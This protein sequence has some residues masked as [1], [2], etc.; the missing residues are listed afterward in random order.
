[1][2]TAPNPVDVLVMTAADAGMFL[3][4]RRPFA[5]VTIGEEAG[6]DHAALGLSSKEM[7]EHVRLRPTDH[8]RVRAA[9]VRS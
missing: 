5:E 8:D 1:L 6:A 2:E 3:V 4:S 7:L 9:I